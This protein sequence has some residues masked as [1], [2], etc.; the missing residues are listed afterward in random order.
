MK[1]THPLFLTALLLLT[2][3]AL[4]QDVKPNP[5]LAQILQSLESFNH[6]ESST[7]SADGQHLFVTNCASTSDGF[8][9]AGGSISKLEIQPDGTLKMLAPDFAR[10]LTAP[11]GIAVLPKSTRKFRAG[12]LFVSTGYA[13]VIDDKGDRVKDPEKINPGVTV[14]HP[15]TG[16]IL[17]HLPLGPGTAAAGNLGHPVLQPN[18]LCF[19]ADANLYIADGGFGG[20]EL[21]PPVRGRPGVKRIRHPQIDAAAENKVLG[22]LVFIPVRHVPNGVYYSAQDDALYWTTC[23][24]EGDAGGAVYRMPRKEFPHETMIHNVIGAI[25]PLEGLTITPGGS[26]VMSRQLDGDLAYITK[27]QQGRLGFLGYEE[28]PKFALPG[29]IKLLTLKNGNNI[30]YLPEQDPESKEKNKQRLRVILLPSN[31]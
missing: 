21:E 22:E 26:L 9:L 15:E 23:D 1:R 8:L 19:D 6:P 11:H 7:I 27:R 10:G 14:V 17:G 13:R 18:G 28:P 2:P 31:L 25:N 4:S 30:L 24:G 20:D 29:D 5:N 3:R 16:Q 12:S